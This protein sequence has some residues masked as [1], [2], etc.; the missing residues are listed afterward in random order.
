MNVVP[1]FVTDE[2]NVVIQSGSSQEQHL[3]VNAVP[4]TLH[5]GSAPMGNYKYI[6]DEFV[7]YEPEKTYDQQR[8][9]LY[10][11]VEDQMDMLWHAMD[12]DQTPKLEP[13]YSSIKAIKDAYPKMSEVSE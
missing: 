8:Q 12:T 7:P 9:M 2:N 3:D 5:M 13:F 6:N 11:S 4:G 10:P 1:F